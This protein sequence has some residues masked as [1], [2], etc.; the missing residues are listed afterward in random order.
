MNGGRV[1]PAPRRRQTDLSCQLVCLAIRR[2]ARVCQIYEIA[3]RRCEQKL[4]KG[5]TSGFAVFNFP[6]LEVREDSAR[7]LS[8]RTSRVPFDPDVS[9]LATIS[10]PLPRRSACC[11]LRRKRHPAATLQPSPAVSLSLFAVHYFPTER[12]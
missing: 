9:H 11:R 10:P 6:A 8:A 7:A 1:A 3:H 5:K 2:R 4:A 12:A